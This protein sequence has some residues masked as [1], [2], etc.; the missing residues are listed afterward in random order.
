M[1]LGDRTMLKPTAHPRVDGQV[2]PGF[3]PVRSAFVDNFIERGE[4]GGAVCVVVDGEVVVDL[5]GGYGTERPVP[6]GAP[7]P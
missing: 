2:A 5:W 6:R 7:T 3:D 4:L 1:A